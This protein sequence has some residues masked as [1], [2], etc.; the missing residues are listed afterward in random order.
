MVKKKPNSV[1][2][3]SYTLYTF[4]LISKV[5]LRHLIFRKPIADILFSKRVTIYSA[6]HCINIEYSLM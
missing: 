5:K 1:Y 3:E 6:D 2:A 4:Y